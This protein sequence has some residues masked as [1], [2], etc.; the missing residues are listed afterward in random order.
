M[1]WAELGGCKISELYALWAQ[2]VKSLGLRSSYRG[3]IGGV[4]GYCLRS[5]L[6]LGVHVGF[7]GED[8]LGFRGQQRRDQVSKPD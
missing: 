4:P 8:H 1:L 5:S 2:E 6:R 3:A 7:A